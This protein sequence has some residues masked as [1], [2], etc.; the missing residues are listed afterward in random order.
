[1]SRRCHVKS[2]IL[3]R[4]PDARYKRKGLLWSQFRSKRRKMMKEKL[5][6]KSPR[7]V[8]ALMTCHNWIHLR[9]INNSW[10][11]WWESEPE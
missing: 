1:M 6:K 3:E 5:Q 11:I 2:E 9:T 10:T 4:L 7:P 8:M